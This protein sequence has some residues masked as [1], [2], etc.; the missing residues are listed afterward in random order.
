MKVV[1]RAKPAG[2]LFTVDIEVGGAS[3][4]H[5]YQML[6]DSG[7]SIVSHNTVSLL[8]GVTPGAHF[9]NSHY[10][11]RRVRLMKDSPLLTDLTAAGYNIEPCIGSEKT[12]V[13]VEFPIAAAPGLRT[14]SEVSIWEK[15]EVAAL[16]QADWADNQVSVTVDFDAEKEKTQ[17]EPVLNYYQYR[18]KSVSF[19]PRYSNSQAYPQMPYEEITQEKFLELNAK[20]KPLN[21]NVAGLSKDDEKE[22]DTHCDGEGCLIPKRKK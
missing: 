20:L 17:I 21:F 14:C 3:G 10:Y 16:L 12:T 2:K 7:Q 1:R 13:V 15:A 5:T 18:L 9:P 19:L 4:T 11:I 8:A 22:T 6:T